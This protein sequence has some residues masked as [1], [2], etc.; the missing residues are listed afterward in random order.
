[1]EAVGTLAG[2]ISH[3]FNNLIQAVHGYTQILL[4]DK[5]A[6]D[7][8]FSSLKA[9]EN[10]SHRAADLVR[11]LM[12]FSRKAETKRRPVA[13]NQ[14][15]E[16]AQRMLG[17]TIPKMIDIQLRLGSR[18][19]P[20]QADPVQMEQILLNL[21]ANAADAMPD[22]GRLVIETQNI[23]LDEDYPDTHLGARP[24][25]YVLLAISDTGHG[26]DKETVE[27]IFEP[28]FT[29]KDLQQGTGLGL[30]TVYGIV[31]SHGGHINCYSEIGHGTTFK[32]YLPAAEPP[33]SEQAETPAPPPPQGGTE[34]ILLVDDEEPIRSFASQAL[35]RF[36]YTVRTASAGEE[37]L[38]IYTQNP[39][40]IDL[41]VLDI[42]MPGMGGHKCLQEI[43]RVDPQAKVLVASGYSIN[44]QMRKTL[45]SG[46]QGYVAKPY[47]LADLLSQVR[48]TLDGVR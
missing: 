15:V 27:R 7:P 37:A 29:T 6:E 46:A 19:W 25:R 21:G 9:I 12:L 10:A 2:G 34:T 26:M 41:V 17:R 44:G 43:L 11:Q 8:D 4:L 32:I 3:D 28:F 18:L 1:M 5:T 35:E 40:Q 42:G 30:A 31:Q 16:Q 14:E 39:D 45:Q 20:I 23:T 22:G 24:G 13:L 33:E 48:D 36:G 47:R 38:E